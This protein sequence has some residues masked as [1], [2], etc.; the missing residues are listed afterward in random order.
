MSN[1][2]HKSNDDA[3]TDLILVKSSNTC[4]GCYY[5]YNTHLCPR[6]HTTHNLICVE[7]RG[8]DKYKVGGLHH[9]LGFRHFIK[10]FES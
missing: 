9:K 6:R 8:Y 4:Q 5:E 2:I 7:K 1:Q 3:N 10:A